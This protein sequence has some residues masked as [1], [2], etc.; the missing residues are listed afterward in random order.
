M[1]TLVKEILEC[2]HYS[3]CCAFSSLSVQNECRVL[4]SCDLKLALIM[5]PDLKGLVN[6]KEK[7]VR[8]WGLVSC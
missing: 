4:D 2:L 7:D 3:L 1:I 6:T 8:Y 5:S